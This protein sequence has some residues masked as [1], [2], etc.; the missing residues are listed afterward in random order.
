MLAVSGSE[1]ALAASRISA[2]VSPNSETAA[3]PG[4]RMFRNVQRASNI[5][6]HGRGNAASGAERAACESGKPLTACDNPCEVLRRCIHR[7][8]QRIQRRRKRV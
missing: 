6:A 3:K 7:V 2:T 1:S 8:R 5:A 4:Q